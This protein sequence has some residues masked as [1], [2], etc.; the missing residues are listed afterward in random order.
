MKCWLAVLSILFLSGGCGLGNYYAVDPMIESTKISNSE[1]QSFYVD[2]K[3]KI[4]T[5]GNAFKSAFTSSTTNPSVRNELLSRIILL[6]DE[7][8]EE[9]KGSILANSAS[10]NVGLGSATT[11][12]SSLATVVGGDAAKSGLS[13]ASAITNSSRSIINDEIY[14]NS[15]AIAIIK[16]IDNDRESKK[17]TIKTGM[18]KS[19]IDY[20]ITQGILDVNS[21]HNSCSFQNGLK[22][23][24]ESVDRR[25]PTSIELREKIDYIKS[26]I[27]YN[28]AKSIS[29]DKLKEHLAEMQGKYSESNY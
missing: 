1:G 3:K 24:S 13:A 6:S 8:C 12:F 9:H 17:L 4:D 10:V 21:Y 14:Y 19:V 15:F 2:G 26:Q 18:N 11:I 7:L 20:T 16:A 22:I 25:K 27:D 23:V 29:S 5:E 28:D